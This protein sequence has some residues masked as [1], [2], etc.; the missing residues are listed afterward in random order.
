MNRIDEIIR[1]LNEG[2]GYKWQY[3]NT[4]Y[5]IFETIKYDG[6]LPRFFIELD[7]G[8]VGCTLE[9]EDDFVMLT[10]ELWNKI[11]TFFTEVS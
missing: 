1:L 2:T 4:P 8:I 9:T 7:E 11:I 3:N 6:K 10:L 5:H